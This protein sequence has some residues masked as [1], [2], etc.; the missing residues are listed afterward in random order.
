MK[1]FI[2][3]YLIILLIFGLFVVV[4]SNR[5]EQINNEEIKVISESYMK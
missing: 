4:A 2:I 5:I 1:K 3:G